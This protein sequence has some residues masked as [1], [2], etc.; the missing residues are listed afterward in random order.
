MSMQPS[1]YTIIGYDLSSY[2]DELYTED[3]ANNEEE[4]W[5]CNQ[6]K[7]NIQLFTDP[8]SGEHLYFGRVIGDGDYYDYKSSVFDLS[9]LQN[10]ESIIKNTLLEAFPN[11]KHIPQISVIC[12]CE[13][14]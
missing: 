5:T 2:Y 10:E 7:G 8:C 1:Y 6:L 3:F 12:F 13:W 9:K 11:I 4:K 14:S